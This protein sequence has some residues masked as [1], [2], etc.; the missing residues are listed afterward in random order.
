MTLIKFLSDT[1]EENI[2]S[3]LFLKPEQLI[4]FGENEKKLT[5]AQQNLKKV[6]KSMSLGCTVSA[7]RVHLDDYCGTAERLLQIA[8]ER[9]D[10]VFDITGGDSR[11]IAAAAAAAAKSDAP[12]TISGT[13]SGRLQ[14]L[15]GKAPHVTPPKKM[16]VGENIRLFGGVISSHSTPD[17]D[18]VRFFSIG[19]G[20]RA[21]ILKIWDIC[22]RD[23]VLWNSS[24]R[25]LRNITAVLPE[26]ERGLEIDASIDTA[27]KS[28]GGIQQ[29]Y[30]SMHK[31]MQQ[32]YG[33]HILTSYEPKNNSFKAAFK[34]RNVRYALSRAGTALEL[35]TYLAAID[36]R[37]DGKPFFDSGDTGVILDWDG[38]VYGTAAKASA[39][40]LIRPGEYIPD[41]INEVDVLLMRNNVPYFISCKNGQTSSDEL[42]KL[43][44]V[45]ARFGGK[46]AK[47][48]LVM[49][50][51]EPDELFIQRAHEMN[52]R[53]IRHADKMSLTDLS[54]RLCESN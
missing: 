39:G 54:R 51:Y 28:L 26:A 2:I 44:A 9:H 48:L 43:S 15:R 19:D 25:T 46:N 12:L 35:F 22:R 17:A 23:C 5:S 13:S 38:T 52:I 45:A 37:I 7:E 33:A 27:E 47:K 29:K 53:L 36:A 24:L 10:C 21:D 8:A 20:F 6:F 50:C 16:T 34:N 11:G 49:T 32:L 4:L 31:I 41:V 1:A 3:A 18:R 42:Y 14:V 30:G 40:N